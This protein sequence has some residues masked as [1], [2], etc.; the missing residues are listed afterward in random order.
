M[1]LNKI[2]L[3]VKKLGRLKKLKENLLIQ[4][5]HWKEP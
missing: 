4:K 3:L 1:E 5:L 2:F